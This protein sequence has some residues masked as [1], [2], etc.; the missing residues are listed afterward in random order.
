MLLSCISDDHANDGDCCFL[1]WGTTRK[2][3][4]VG[5]RI[6]ESC[7]TPR[8]SNWQVDG[9]DRRT[10]R[11]RCEPCTW[12][13]K[14]IEVQEIKDPA[15]KAPFVKEMPVSSKGMIPLDR[16]KEFIEG[17]IKDKYEVSTKSSH[18]YAKPYT[19][20]ID[21]FKMLVGYQHPKFQQ[22]EEQ[23]NSTQH[24]THFVM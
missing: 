23:G 6:D 7:T 2:C 20:R 15:K 12:K 4:K 9:Q 16:L 10:F 19:S 5:W 13:G 14:G 8:I 18:M 11:W 24:V 22:F 17:T 3:E 1:S 21:N